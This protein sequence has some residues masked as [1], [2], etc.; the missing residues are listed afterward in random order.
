MN[1]TTAGKHDAAALVVFGQTD[2]G[3]RNAAWFTAAESANAKKAA[4][5]SSMAVI[6]PIPGELTPLLPKIA[7]GRFVMGQLSLSKA[8]AGAYGK[9]LDYVT[10]AKAAAAATAEAEI[11]A[12]VVD[13]APEGAMDGPA[14][15]AAD[16]STSPTTAELWNRLK[17]GDTVLASYEGWWKARVIGIYGDRVRVAWD[18]GEADEFD[19]V[20]R[21]SVALL[22][23]K[24]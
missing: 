24:A 16:T 2:K 17:I 15:Q 23:P 3:A 22:L 5:L 19:E 9:L 10:A 20:P 7:R 21:A 18:G 8:D 14:A 6:D 12:E 4:T 1:D 13:G 11:D